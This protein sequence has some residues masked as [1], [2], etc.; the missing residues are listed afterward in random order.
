M[1]SPAWPF[2]TERLVLRPFEG[3]DLDAL[4]AIHSDAGVARWLYN[5]PRL[6]EETR[7]RN[8]SAA[9]TEPLADGA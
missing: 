8:P 1:P 7:E 4:H 3:D 6:L 9:D 2:H 5:D